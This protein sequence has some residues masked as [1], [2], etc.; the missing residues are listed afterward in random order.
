MRK[1]QVTSSYSKQVQPNTN[2]VIYSLFALLGLACLFALGPWFNP[3]TSAQTA[4]NVPLIITEFRLRGPNGPNDEFI[5][6]YNNSDLPHTVNSVDGTSSGYAL[7]GSSNAIINDQLPATRFVIP[8]G[9]VIPARAHLLATNSIGYTLTNYPAGNGTSATPDITYTIQIPDNVG[10]ALF[11]TGTAFNYTFANRI[12]AVG[13]NAD[14]NSLYR[15]G[16]GYPAIPSTA[17][18]GSFFRKLLGGCTGSLSGNCTTIAQLTTTLGPS[19]SYPQDT[20]NNVDDFLFGDTGATDTGASRR[21]STPGPENLSGPITGILDPGLVITRLDSTVAEDSGPNRA[22]NTTPGNLQNSTFGTLTFRRR[23]TNNVGQPITRLRFRIVDITTLP[24]IGSGCNVEPAPANCAADLRTLS[25]TNSTVSV[26]DPTVCAPALTPC[27]VFV[28]GTTLEGP[29]VQP[30]GGGF[31]SSWSVD[32]ISAVT[33]LGVGASLNLQF[34]TGLQQTGVDRLFVLVEALPRSGPATT[35]VVR[36]AGPL[37]PSTFQFEQSVYSVTEDLTATSVTVLRSGNNNVAASIDF[38][39]NDSSATQKQ[40]YTIARGTLTFAPGEVS[41]TINLL[42][43]EDSKTEG[44]ESFT[45]NL[46]NPSTGAVIGTPGNTSVQIVDDGP[47]SSTNVIDDQT[48]FVGQHYHDFLNR[49]GD[50]AGVTFWTDT[51]TSCGVDQQCID[52]KR[53][54]ASAAFFLSTEFQE[55]SFFVIRTQRVA[56]GRKS[57]TAASRLSYLEFVRDAR[58]VGNGVIIGQPGA[59]QQLENNKQAYATDIESSSNFRAR[60]PLA[61]TADQYVDALFSSATVVPTATERQAAILAFGAGGTTGRVAALRNVTDSDSVND[62]EFNAAFVLLQYYGYLRRNPT[63]QP[64]NNDNGYQFWL[65]K[66][67]TFGG[68]FINAE[69]V[70]AFIL[71]DEYRNRFGP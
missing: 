51:I 47:E 61:Q 66:L 71:S 36:L 29:P 65:N 22:R 41:K 10:I 12:D 18:E 16:A 70:K 33:P 59:E 34:V 14:N 19:S 39:T 24:S 43:N 11:G 58:R 56:F 55:T 28:Q 53:I 20:G 4:A 25:A 46:N 15:E 35:A 17:L 32:S 48:V 60:F 50:S 21:L 6:I 3:P 57:D 44:T 49:Q 63:D 40:D 64:D 68:N 67:N 69:M 27:S 30:F 5:E 37:P 1:A 45:V 9:T 31:N 52:V 13:S 38:A 8:N 2:R 42:I 26:N 7:V 23:I 62:A 54:N